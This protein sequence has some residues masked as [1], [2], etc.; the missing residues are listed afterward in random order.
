VTIAFTLTRH[1]PAR[2]A[3]VYI[4]AQLAGATLA[5]LLLLGIWP[6]QPAGLGA[7]TPSISAGSAFVYEL[8]LT[9]FL[10][11]ETI[12]ARLSSLGV[13]IGI[14]TGGRHHAG[15]AAAAIRA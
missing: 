1:F 5:A 9:A 7:T 2:E 10:M 8:V 13:Q 15:D 14:D 6:S 12:G 4:A 11:F 3:L